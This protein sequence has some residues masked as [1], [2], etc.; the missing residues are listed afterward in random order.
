MLYKTC[1]KINTIYLHSARKSNDVSF[2]GMTADGPYLEYAVR[3]YAPAVRIPLTRVYSDN[4]S[5]YRC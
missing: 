4:N 1:R 2:L 5:H 3:T